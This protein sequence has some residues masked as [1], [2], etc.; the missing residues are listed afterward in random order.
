MAIINGT[1]FRI[2]VGDNTITG[3]I[4][5]NLSFTNSLVNATIGDTGSWEESISGRRASR[6]TFEAYDFNNDLQ[7]GQTYEVF[8]GPDVRGWRGNAL[9]ESLDTNADSDSVVVISGQFKIIG[10]LERASTIIECDLL[11]EDG[12]NLLLENGDNTRINVRTFT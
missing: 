12:C 6:I 1:Q 10:A 11:L 3:E 8:I 9:I 4:T 7:L 5:S 2:L